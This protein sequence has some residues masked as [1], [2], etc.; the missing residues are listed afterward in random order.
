[1]RLPFRTESVSPSHAEPNSD[2]SE[3]QL[4]SEEIFR[5]GGTVSSG[6]LL[7]RQQCRVGPVLGPMRTYRLLIC[8]PSKTRSPS[9]EVT[10]IADG[11]TSYAISELDRPR[12]LAPIGRTALASKAE[13]AASVTSAEVVMARSYRSRDPRRLP[14]FGGQGQW[15]PRMTQPAPRLG[16]ERINS[17]LLCQL[18]YR[19]SSNIEIDLVRRIARHDQASASEASCRFQGQRGTGQSSSRGSL[20]CLQ[21][22]IACSPASPPNVRLRL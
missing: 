22:A 8:P 10:G 1:M 3:S 17:A 2:A 7:D 20:G 4:K 21:R 16:L 14:T 18:S 19:G 11:V 9:R 13:T 6:V 12:V 5:E 15:E